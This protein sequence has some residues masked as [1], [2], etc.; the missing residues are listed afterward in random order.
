MNAPA[1]SGASPP[2]QMRHV[3]LPLFAPALCRKLAFEATFSWH[4][5]QCRIRSRG[6]T[7]VL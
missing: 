6:T 1:A 2:K 5:P 7:D 3:G 4:L